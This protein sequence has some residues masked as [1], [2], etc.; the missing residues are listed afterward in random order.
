MVE[1]WVESPFQLLGAL[2]AHA[3][4]LLGESLDVVP[5]A[6]L[7]PLAVTV[8]ELTRLGLPAG[9]TVRPAV[10]APA[11]GART[12]AVGDVFS[13]RVQQLLAGRPPHRVVLLDD[14]RATLRMLQALSRR[15][16]PLVRPHAPASALRSA[17][18]RVTL[19]RLKH[20]A[21]AG[22]LDV[23]TALDVPPELVDAARRVGVQVHRH[24]FGWLRSQPSDVPAAGPGPVVLGSS[25]VANGLIHAEPYLEWVRSIAANSPTGPVTYRAHRRED[26]R[27]LRPLRAAGVD[28]R[29]GAVP[30]EVS[31]RGM[32]LGQQVVT[33]PTTAASTLRMLAP[34]AR[35]SEYA[36]PETWWQAGVSDVT[37]QRLVPEVSSGP[38]APWRRLGRL[39]AV[40]S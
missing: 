4:G 13:G 29:S 25:M 37:R 1:A 3:E 35:V 15:D 30:V 21:R 8:A 27:T 23:V 26:E 19:A 9:S 36:V 33:L 10:A 12:L 38:A 18:A 16:V 28:V 20:L 40:A 14:G 22:R 5:R 31:L 11:R 6:G 2:E 17:L 32:A 39:S 24:S 34:Q 7:E